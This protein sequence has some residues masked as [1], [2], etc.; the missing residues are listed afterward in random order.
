M[1]MEIFAKA[2]VAEWLRRLTRNQLG[3]ARTGSNPVHCGI[4]FLSFSV[5]L[6][7]LT[8]SLDLPVT[9]I[10]QEV[11]NLYDMFHTRNALHRRAY[12]HKTSNIIEVM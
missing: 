6:F 7:F 10:V 3:S 11:G 2:V 4:L 9:V 5:Q 1:V 8:S 12:Q